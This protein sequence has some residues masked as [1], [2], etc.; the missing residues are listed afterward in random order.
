MLPHGRKLAK[1]R[2]KLHK[3]AAETFKK[4]PVTRALVVQRGGNH[5]A[6][7]SL[8][9]QA[10]IMIEMRRVPLFNSPNKITNLRHFR[11]R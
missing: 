4:C 3:Q 1:C 9:Y 2:V 11:L 10:C 7:W 8:V 5:G 6:T